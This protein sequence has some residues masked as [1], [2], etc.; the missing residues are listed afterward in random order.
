VPAEVERPDV[1]AAGQALLGEAPEAAA[2]GA[3]AVQADDLRG[4]LGA[5]G[6]LVEPQETFPSSASTSGGKVSC[7]SPT[8]P[9]SA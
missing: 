6:V 5:P 1:V 9:K 8:T 3:D 2:V 7:Q 4:A